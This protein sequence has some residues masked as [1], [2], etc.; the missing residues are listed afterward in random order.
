M[1]TIDSIENS[2]IYP[3]KSTSNLKKTDSSEFTEIMKEKSIIDEFSEKYNLNVAGSSKFN[4]GSMTTLTIA[5]NILKEMANNPQRK[6]YYEGVIKDYFDQMPQLMTF[7]AATDSVPLPTTITFNSD[8][9]WVESGGSEPSPEKLARI[10]K[11][12]EEKKKKKQEE[13]EIF[14]DIS[15]PMNALVMSSELKGN[16]LGI[17]KI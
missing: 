8:G 10:K 13:E 9:S 17:N 5:P 7:Y 4:L 16:K 12:Q 6:A 3:Q 11:E 1:N 15:N 2:N 14:N